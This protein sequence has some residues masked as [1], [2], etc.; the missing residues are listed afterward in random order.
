MSSV[1]LF[2]VL[3]DVIIS[4]KYL[5]LDVEGFDDSLVERHV[6]DYSA[7]VMDDEMAGQDHVDLLINKILVDK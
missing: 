1:L 6:S 3:F 5:T 7:L 2:H 4:G